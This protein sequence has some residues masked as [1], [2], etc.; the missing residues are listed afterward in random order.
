MFIFNTR[1]YLCDFDKNH[2]AQTTKSSA[3]ITISPIWD[4]NVQCNWE[5]PGSCYYIVTKS[6]RYNVF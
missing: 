3:I 2:H 5:K 4:L 6:K 1:I